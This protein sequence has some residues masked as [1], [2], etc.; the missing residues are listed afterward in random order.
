MYTLS[1]KFLSVVNQNPQYIK[2]FWFLEPV[3]HF[4]SREKSHRNQ[5]ITVMRNRTEPQKMPQIAL[6]ERQK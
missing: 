4:S 1:S 5:R 2:V 3:V 6:N